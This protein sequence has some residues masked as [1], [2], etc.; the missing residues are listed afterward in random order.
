MPAEDTGAATRTGWR[1]P[2]GLLTCE[3]LLLILSVT[4]CNKSNAEA[5]PVPKN[6]V[7]NVED[8]SFQSYSKLACLL[9]S[10]FFFLSFF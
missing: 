2:S 7:T 6:R 4:L 8:L 3:T 10:S 5:N 1:P 9:F